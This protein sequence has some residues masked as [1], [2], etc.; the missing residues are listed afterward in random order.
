MGNMF[1]SPDLSRCVP[2][3]SEALT[4]SMVVGVG[5]IPL[6]C[7]TFGSWLPA[8][9]RSDPVKD[10]D[11]VWVTEWEKSGGSAWS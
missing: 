7:A 10:D 6:S 8:K 5:H 3:L 11:L 9:F 2:C 1:L 4:I